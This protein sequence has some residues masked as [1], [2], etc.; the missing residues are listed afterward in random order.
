M[1][2]AV[3]LF[4]TLV[5]LA[6][7]SATP[8]YAQAPPALPHAFCGSVLINGDPAPDGTQVSAT[9]ETGEIIS[10]Q[11][12]V[13]TEN[14]NYGID[15]LHLLV[16]GYDLSGAIKFYVN[17]VEVEGVTAIFEAE[18][19]PTP[20]NLDLVS[21]ITAQKVVTVP[22]GQ[23]DYV[24]DFSAEAGT[25]ITVNTTAQV[26]VQKYADNPHPGVALP[27]NMLP[28]YIDI[29]IDVLGNIAWPMHV[30][31]TYT[32]AEVAGLDES[33]LRMYYFKDAAWHECSDTGVNTATNTIWANMTSTELWGSPI[34]FGG[35][36]APEP[37][38]VGGGGGGGYPWI[39]VIY[40]GIL[41]SVMINLRGELLQPLFLT[42]PDGLFTFK[43]GYFAKVLTAEGKL[44]KEIE[45]LKVA[46][47]PSPPANYKIVGDVYELLPSGLTFDPPATLRLGFDPAELPEEVAEEDLSIAY[48]DG[49]EWSSLASTVNAEADT[50]SCQLSHFTMFAIIG[51]VTP[52]PAPTPATFTLTL[53]GISPAEVAPGEEVT[54]TVSVANTGGTE[55]SYTVVLNINDVKEAEKDVTVTAGE[56]QKVG[57]TVTRE[58][59][60]DYAVMVSGL[61]G[62]FTVK[63]PPAPVPAPAPAPPAKPISW[64]LIGGLIAGGVIVVLLIF[65]LVR[66]SR[67]Y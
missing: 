4:V 6:T 54:I 46:E 24:I 64:Y 49:S 7:V 23:T 20:Q 12:P 44:P 48:W 56:S 15:G 28:I 34:A 32:T 1:R 8:A 41:S 14:G 62:S 22:A 16:Q 65:F 26:T 30:E 38:L 43:I 36:A 60:G 67:A 59:P 58:E 31:Q 25:T 21:N 29:D 61:G 50:V 42:S 45:I 18:G 9:V 51:A 53:A 13:A 19:G 10:T 33:S 11:N 5:L 63:A 66:R 52:P 37:P 35:A 40:E 57:F 17:G 3:I 47:P 2:K 39:K 27:A 55:G